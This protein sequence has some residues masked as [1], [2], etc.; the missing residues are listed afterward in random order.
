MPRLCG[1]WTLANSLTCIF[2]GSQAF[3]Q[4]TF[5][6]GV[7]R[8]TSGYGVGWASLVAVSADFSGG[9]VLR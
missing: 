5:P 3:T 4:E 2:Y 8:P 7:L 6:K 9:T 1:A